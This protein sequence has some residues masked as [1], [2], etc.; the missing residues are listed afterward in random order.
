[1]TNTIGKNFDKENIIDIQKNNYMKCNDLD[2][3]NS[4][5]YFKTSINEK[6][7]STEDI[8]FDL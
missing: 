8:P 5:Q 3:I 4:D 6:I 1:M 7:N 2:N